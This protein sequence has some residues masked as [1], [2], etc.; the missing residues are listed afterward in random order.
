MEGNLLDY[1]Q[2]RGDLS[3]RASPFNDVDA[4]LLAELSHL[5]YPFAAECEMTLIEA[6]QKWNELPENERFKGLERIREQ[7]GKLLISAAES[8]RFGRVR[9]TRY[10][11]LKDEQAEMEFSAV[12]FLLPEKTVF[13][14]Y[15]GTGDDLIGWKEDLNMVFME[16][17]PS[18]KEAARYAEEAASVYPDRDLILGGQSKG[19]NL[20]VWAGAHLSSDLKRRLNA[21]YNLDGPGFI[22]G[23]TR[24]P[25]YGEISGRVISYVPASSLVGVLMGECPYTCIK[26]SSLSVLQHDPFT[27]MICG[28][29]FVREEARSKSGELIEKYV[30]GLLFNMSRAGREEFVEKLFRDL[31]AYNAKTVSD[32]KKHLFITIIKVLLDLKQFSGK[33]NENKQRRQELT[34]L[35]KEINASKG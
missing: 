24:K 23:L 21:V 20:A 3:F 4:L 6:V 11:E 13:I 30:D 7:T 16:A 14:A 22:G 15:R 32:L 9:V 35:L 2:W 8:T 5:R 19:G 26:S 31:T 10:S 27:W 1:L 18:Q 17:V 25:E 28:T 12:C 34:A 33:S 29:S